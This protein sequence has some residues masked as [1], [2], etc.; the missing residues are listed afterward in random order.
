DAIFVT[1]TNLFTSIFAGF[2]IFSIIGYLAHQT[3]LPIEDTVRSGPGLAF[4]AYPEAVVRMPLPNMWAVLFFLMLFILGLGSQFAGIQAINSAILDVRPS[5]RKHESFVILGICACGWLAA[6]PMI[7][8]GGVYLYTLMDWNT[9]SWAILLIG[10]AEVGIPAWCYGCNKFLD[11]IEEMKMSLS[12]VAR[13][14]WWF[15]WM[16]LAPITAL[17]RFSTMGKRDWHFDRTDYTS[18]F[19][20]L[21]LLLPLEGTGECSIDEGGSQGGDGSEIGW[22]PWYTH[23][24]TGVYLVRRTNGARRKN[25]NREEEIRGQSGFRIKEERKKNDIRREIGDG[26]RYFLHWLSYNYCLLTWGKSGEDPRGDSKQNLIDK[27]ARLEFRGD[28]QVSNKGY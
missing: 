26:F 10:I 15:S 24:E 16:I 11:N 14:Y 12:C 20:T 19:T 2:V 6:I 9:A 25:L 1:L 17:L 7:Y 21:L 5:L 8:D 13:Y 27:I 4:V 18:T 22:L 23:S 28:S 3:N